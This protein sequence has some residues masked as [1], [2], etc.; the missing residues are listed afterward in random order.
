MRV[1]VKLAVHDHEL[2][3]D[4]FFLSLFPDPA[5]DAHSEHDKVF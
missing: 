4:I 3:V 5:V 2:K 1:K